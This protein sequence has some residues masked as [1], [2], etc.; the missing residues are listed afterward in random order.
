MS[1]QH[2]LL[3]NTLLCMAANPNRF[4]HMTGCHCRNLSTSQRRNQH[5]LAQLFQLVA[6]L[7]GFFEFQ[8]LRGLQHFLFKPLDLFG[9]GDWGLGNRGKG[10]ELVARDIRFV[11]AQGYR[12][13]IVLGFD[14]LSTN[15]A[16]LNL[17][18]RRYNTPPTP[19][20][21]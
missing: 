4:R 16:S 20:F 9:N 11:R 21:H 7:G 1:Q 18:V 6:Q 14:R 2:Y 17:G 5:A 12:S 19:L 13:Q 3:S 10:L 15:G 8:I